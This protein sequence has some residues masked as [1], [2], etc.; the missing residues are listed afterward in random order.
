[1][2]RF[3][4]FALTIVLALGLIVG[5]SEPK[6]N[7]IQKETGAMK[8]ENND[9]LKIAYITMDLSSPY[10]A[11][12]IDGMNEKAEELGVD[13][14]V[15]DGKSQVQ[16][17]IDIMDTLITQKVNVIILSANDAQALKP[18]IDKARDAG[19]KVVTAN[20]EPETEVDAHVSLVEYDY[21]LMGGEIA[22]EWIKE[23]LDN[24]PAVAILGNFQLPAV[25]KRFEGLKDGILKH[26]PDAKVVAEQ[27]GADRE[28]GMKAVETILQANPNL[29]VV[30]S[31]TDDGALGAYE[32]LVAAGKTGDD[33]C[34]VGLDAVEE[35]IQK[36]K[37]NTIYRG[38][39]DIQPFESGKLIIETAIKVFKE[40]P[41][42]EMI[43]FPMEPITKD[44]VD[45]IFGK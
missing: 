35:A 7:G 13:L 43:K 27:E 29:Q 16:P 28:T 34:V 12:M 36:I 14:S 38:T 40:G 41:M 25:L 39:V 21:G 11:L 1:M 3:A 42:E 33:I 26:A 44:N 2:K 30:V 24:A 18:S 37:D 19:I 8:E 17:Q 45:E 20:L 31:T 22:G 6:S 4:L 23:N 32:A 10:F 5:C 15:H 9:N